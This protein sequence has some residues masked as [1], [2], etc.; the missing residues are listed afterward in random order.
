[1]KTSTALPT[2]VLEELRGDSLCHRAIRC[3]TSTVMPVKELFDGLGFVY[4]EQT[5]TFTV[6]TFNVAMTGRVRAV[7]RLSLGG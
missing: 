7:E 1:L 6:H 4:C 3:L 5:A 2:T